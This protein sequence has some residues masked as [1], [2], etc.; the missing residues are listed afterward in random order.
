[1]LKSLEIP[2]INQRN[3]AS[4][5]DR[6][7]TVWLRGSESNSTCNM[8]ITLSGPEVER[9]CREQGV[10]KAFP[11]KR[12]TPRDLSSPCWKPYIKS[13]NKVCRLAQGCWCPIFDAVQTLLLQ[14]R[15]C[16]YVE[17]WLKVGVP[18]PYLECREKLALL[19]GW[20]VCLPISP[21][22]IWSQIS[23]SAPVARYKATLFKNRL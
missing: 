16:I 6:F 18:D 14:R 23:T 7:F 5:D 21:R 1:M 2:I 8:K 4:W 22:F 9:G 12:Y 15:A 10:V 17:I 20:G 13:T 3:L 11:G 19:L